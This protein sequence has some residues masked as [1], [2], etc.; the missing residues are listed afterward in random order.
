MKLMQF[1]L[2]FVCFTSS[3][4]AQK[5]PK[6]TVEI[7]T[8]SILLGNYFQVKFTLENASGEHFQA[9]V[10][11]GF[12]IVSGPN[13]SSSISIVNGEVSQMA[14]YTFYLQPND[15]GNYYIQPA[16]IQVEENVLET[17]P[18]QVI[19]VP[20]PDGV[21]QTPQMTEKFNFDLRMP[22]MNAKPA[23]KQEEMKPQAKK[24]KTYKI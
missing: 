3:L 7:S 10:F 11:E 20:N 17:I 14:S 9:P 24:R 5:A 12:Q 22:D 21:I 6:F 18:L 1:T 23:P 19:V 15:I 2:L 16:S 13:T 8:D 4:L